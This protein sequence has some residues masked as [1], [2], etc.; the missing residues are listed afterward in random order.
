MH[1][2]RAN[3]LHHLCTMPTTRSQSSTQSFRYNMYHNQ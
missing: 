2:L 3:S 1:S